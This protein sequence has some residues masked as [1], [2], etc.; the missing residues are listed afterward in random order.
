[1]PPTTKNVERGL[2]YFKLAAAASEQQRKRVKEDLSFQVPDKQWPDEVQAA[3]GATTIGGV[4]IPARPMLSV[5][6]VD[7][8]IQLVSNQERAAHLAANFHPFSEDADDDTAQVLQALYNQ[9]ANASNAA[10]A[11]SWA[12]ERTL[13]CGEGWYRLITEYD[14]EG[15]HPFDQ[16]ICWRR[17]KYQ[18]NN[19]PDPFAQQADKS[20]RRWHIVVEDVPID[21]Y[22]VQYPKSHLTSVNDGELTSIGSEAPNWIGGD[23]EVSRTIRVAE[24]YE[25]ENETRTW[26]LYDDGQVYADDAATAGPV[27]GLQVPPEGA[28]PATG[29][30]ARSVDQELRR[31]YWFKF[32]CYEELEPRELQDGQWIPIVPVI[33]R[34]LQPFDGQDRIV[35][36]I[37]NAKDSARLINYA[38]S[39]AV[40]MAALEPRAPFNL[41]PRQIE[42]YEPFWQQS[43]TRNFPFLPSHQFVDGQQ[44]NPPARMQVD[45]SRLGPNMQILSM[46]GQMLQS[47]MSTFDPALGKQ[48]TAHRS[49]RA[50]E[51][52]Q[53]QTQEANS[54]YLDNLATISIPYEALV[55]LDLAPKIYDRKERVV[56][57]L[58]GETL[59]ERKSELVMLGAP[60]TTNPQT[61]RPQVAVPGTAGALEFNLNKGRYGL[62]VTIG[63]S[64]PSRLKEGSDS[65]SAILQAEPKL[66]PIVGPEWARFQD[67]PGSKRLADLLQKMRDHE[68]PWL[69]DDAAVKAQAENQQLKGQ[70]QAAME[71]AARMKQDLDTQRVKAA[72]EAQTKLAI[73]DLKARTDIEL[74]RMKDATQIEVARISAAKEAMQAELAAREEAI[75]LRTSLAAEAFEA[76]T[77]RA[78]E[79]ATST[80][81]HASA[82]DQ[83]AQG[84]VHGAMQSDADRQAAAMAAAQAE[85]AGPPAE[86]E[87]GV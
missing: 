78:H 55:F 54:H 71:A 61:K 4:P 43:N 45:T 32:N 25:I 79:V 48:P 81:D 39:G 18:G 52:L 28:K 19:Y 70:L 15:G 41:D 27:A 66:M 23:E 5:A 44:F 7:E 85:P 30:E 63:K 47:A 82:L 57:I 59:D 69:A 36:M 80:L 33:G 2:K 56:R 35:G 22:K 50:L 38:A 20:D 12:Y 40:E 62:S 10:V 67:F 53:G 17:M 6:P 87:A 21:T 26:R 49:G 76:D 3:R 73:E 83:A 46:G 29:N 31:M 64:Q 34:E 13:W 8:P 16:R 68:M 84:A 37:G 24:M 72:F 14:P 11:R 58:R 51:A 75:A 60:Y 42:T 77:G 1:M 65:L 9:C 86:P 74:Q